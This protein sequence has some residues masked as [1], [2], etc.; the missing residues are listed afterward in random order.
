M[1][2]KITIICCKCQKEMPLSK[3]N[4][5]YLGHSFYTDV[6]KCLECGGIFIPEELVKGRIAEVEMQL[7]DK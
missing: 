2:E 1:A 4:F 3:T 7:E 5:N 6:H